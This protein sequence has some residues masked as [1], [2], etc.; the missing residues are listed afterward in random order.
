MDMVT[1]SKLNEIR[2]LKYQFEFLLNDT[3]RKGIENLLKLLNENGF[4]SSPAS[5]KYHGS[6]YGGLLE[7]SLNVYKIFKELIKTYYNFDVEFKNIVIPALLHDLCKMGAYISLN[8]GNY[9]YNKNHEKGHALLS[10]KII[11]QYITL[12]P[13]ERL[14]IKYHMGEYG[15]FEFY[16]LLPYAN[17]EY[18]LKELTDNYNEFPIIKLFHIADELAT[19]KEKN[20]KC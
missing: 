17:G 1:V 14:L 7:H 18:S 4:F 19:I 9:V 5:S 13:I 20:E 6:H 10:L 3:E 12:L 16:D 8:N 2:G 11:E 15:T